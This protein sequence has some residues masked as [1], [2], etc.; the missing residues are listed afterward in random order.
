M[1]RLEDAVQD[2]EDEADFR[3]DQMIAYDDPEAD[4]IDDVEIDTDENGVYK[5]FKNINS[6]EIINPQAEDELD[7]A[8]KQRKKGRQIQILLAAM[9]K[10]MYIVDETNVKVTYV[11]KI[12]SEQQQKIANLT[13]QL[14]EKEE[15]LQRKITELSTK[16]QTIM[17]QQEGSKQD[18]VRFTEQEQNKAKLINDLK[19]KIKHLENENFAVKEA[20]TADHARLEKTL[21]F[22]VKES[23]KQSEQA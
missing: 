12:Y 6:Q 22:R 18:I 9:K 11:K 3:Q 5:I 13:K 17:S 7:E 8:F 10:Q 15:E 23:E 21:N 16:N 19:A 4:K 14:E 20:M 1:Q 2:A